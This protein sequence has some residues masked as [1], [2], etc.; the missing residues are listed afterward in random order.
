MHEIFHQFDEDIKNSVQFEVPMILKDSM[1]YSLM[2]GGKRVRPLL[3]YALLYAFKKDVTLGKSSAL[4]IEYIHT[5]SLIHDDLPA[6][7]NDDYR[8]G[9]LTNH[10]QFDEATAILAG[11][12]LLTQAFG[13]IS[14]DNKLSSSKKIRLISALVESANH[15]GMIGGQ[16]DD[17]QSENKVISVEQLIAIHH[18]KT[19][20]LIQFCI[21]A[22]LIH[23]N[24]SKES[25]KSLHQFA[26]HY[27]LAFQIHN[28]LKDVVEQFDFD[29]KVKGRDEIL[30]KNTYTSMLGVQETK[31]AL[32][33]EI[34]S[35]INCIQKVKQEYSHFDDELILDFLNFIHI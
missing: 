10:K 19:G 7:D 30:H 14:Q 25:E 3:I 22:A 1:L 4:A 21:E 33:R 13:L 34:D 27:G 12:N 32:Q 16:V 18:R 15:N 20:A 28:D 26:K 29:G 23:L 31:R 11:D 35:A 9:K 24:L 5:Y 8:R 6:M 17:I 2:T